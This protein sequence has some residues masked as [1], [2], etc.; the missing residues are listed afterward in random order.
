MWRVAHPA[1]W[2][3]EGT[4]TPASAVED[5][6]A[7]SRAGR[8]GRGG[9][10]DLAASVV[11]WGSLAA[12]GRARSGLCCQTRGQHGAEVA[13]AHP[14]GALLAPLFTSGCPECRAMRGDA[15]GGEISEP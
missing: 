15:E 5:E 10:G 8:A 2:G 4:H 1:S 14:P 13:Q 11:F 9:S 7:C 12:R 6:G 3:C